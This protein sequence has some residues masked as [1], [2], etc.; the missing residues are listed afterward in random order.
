MKQS[1]K[2]HYYLRP[3]VT[4]A[5]PNKATKRKVEQMESSDTEDDVYDDIKRLY[6]EHPDQK[7]ATCSMQACMDSNSLMALQSV[8]N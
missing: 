3:R 2:V 1:Y 6:N 7:Y 5:H 8:A 4:D